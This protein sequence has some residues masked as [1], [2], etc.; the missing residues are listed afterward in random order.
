MKLSTLSRPLA[1]ALLALA[2]CSAPAPAD[3][4]VDRANAL[5]TTIRPNLRSDL[6]LLPAIA[7]MEEP[8]ASVSRLAKAMLLPAGATGWDAAEKWAQGAPQRAVLEALHKVAA[9]ENASEGMAFGQPYGADAIAT[10]SDGIALIKANLYT[11][12]GDPPLLA[13]ARYLYLPALDKVACLVNVEATRLA[14]AG[15]PSEAVALLI[16]WLFFS[17]QMAERQA[18]QETRWGLRSMF[19]AF[20]RIRD[21]VYT[22]FR[23]A[24]ALTVEQILTILERLRG[25]GGY[26]RLDRL[27]FPVGP[28]IA[29]E[30]V[31]AQVFTPEGGPNATFGQT[32]A[33]LA[34]TQR[35]LRLFAEAA[36]WDRIAAGHAVSRDTAKELGRV[37]DDIAARWPLDPFDQRMALINDFERM[38]KGRFAVIAS[39]LPDLTVLFNDRQVLRTEAIGTRDALGVVAFF[40]SAKSFPPKLESIRPRFAKNLE[41][42]PFNPDRA[43]GKQ[44]PLE[45]FV[46]VRDQVAGAGQSKPHEM[47]VIVGDMNFQVRLTE[48][49]FV[50]YSVGPNGAKD[51]AKEVSGEPVKGAIGDMLIW[52]PVL[53]LA[54]QHQLQTGVLK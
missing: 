50:L 41:A 12:L 29:G 45:F 34:S 31:V 16:D 21:V 24:H 3:E 15:K 36:R 51:W 48:D 10:S 20:E 44:P 11:D 42:D 53:S 4:F 47:N 52:P 5:Y 26:L 37:Y 32:M 17:R 6:V 22:D 43:R 54:R 33:R 7:K 1:A 8:P 27:V 13:G 19:A 49:Q 39:V 46:P 9:G 2:V 25:D 28:R 40:Y 14:A 23:G 30:Q 35:P 38:D 18:F